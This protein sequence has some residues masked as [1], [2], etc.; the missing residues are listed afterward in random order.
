MLA[1]HELGTRFTLGN[2]LG[3]AIT[4]GIRND[5][6]EAVETCRCGIK[7]CGSRCAIAIL[8]IVESEAENLADFRGI[9]DEGWWGVDELPPRGVTGMSNVKDPQRRAAAVDECLID[10]IDAGRQPTGWE[11]RAGEPGNGNTAWCDCGRT[12]SGAFGW[13]RGFLGVWCRWV[14]ECGGNH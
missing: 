9:D 14:E 2:A 7:I 11:C 5:D 1:V 12:C 6:L 3:P 4:I 8:A 10:R 13:C